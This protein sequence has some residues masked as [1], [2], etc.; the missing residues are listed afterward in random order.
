[1]LTY[2]AYS[3]NREFMS[4]MESLKLELGA[5]AED[6]ILTGIDEKKYSPFDYRGKNILVVAFICN[7]CPYAQAIWPRLVELQTRYHDRGVRFLGI[8]PNVNNPD[9]E[10][11]MV[12]KLK[13]YAK[14]F[15]MNFPYLIDDTQ[16]VAKKYRAQCTP[17]IYVF[18]REG[19]LAY[20]GRVDDNW[21]DAAKVTRHDLD[22]ALAA[23]A[24]GKK[25]VAVQYP[26]VGCSIKW[27]DGL[28][29]VPSPGK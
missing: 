12:E 22:E 17:D 29:S 14:R 20:H 25:P 13:L 9:Y 2:S 19:K 11:E 8:N 3:I 21:Q 16:E 18:D 24:E 10:E 7:H 28:R 15:K 4:L 23:L 26:S 6:F 5:N 27:K 1:M